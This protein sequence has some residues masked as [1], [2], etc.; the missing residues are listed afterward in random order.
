MVAWS[1]SE[2]EY[3]QKKQGTAG[4]EPATFIFNGHL[5]GAL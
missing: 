2:E 5:Q 1:I 3:P 4:L